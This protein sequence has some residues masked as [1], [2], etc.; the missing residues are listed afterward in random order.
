MTTTQ[1]ER[2]LGFRVT[3]HLFA[4]LAKSGELSHQ[5][6]L[7]CTKILCKAYR[8]VLGCVREDIRIEEIERV[9]LTGEEA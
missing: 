4:E 8:P 2:E 9:H 3:V 6:Y 1:F 7:E 5:E